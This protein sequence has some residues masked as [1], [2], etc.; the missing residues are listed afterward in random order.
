MSR[1]YRIEISDPKSGLIITPPGFD[2]LLG[3]AT[4]TS[5]VN[6]QTLPGAWNIELDVP[7]IGA[8]TPQG[9]A[10][11]RVWGISRQ[12][13]SQANDLRNK[14]IKI[15]GGMQKGLPLADPKQAGLLVQ[16]TIFQPFG[17]W[18]GVDQTLD[19]VIIPG[20]G[21]A[22]QPGGIGTLQKPKNI[23]LNWRA[24]T[25]LSEALGSTL[26]TAFPG[27]KQT[28]QISQSLTRPN[29]EVAFFPTLEQ[30][31][32]FV[33]QTSK[34]IIKTDGYAGVSIVLDGA[35]ISAFDG[36]A[37]GGGAAKAIGYA[38]LIG[39]PTWIESPN[40][41]IKTVMRGDL[42]TGDGI[43]LPKT[44]VTNTQQAASALVNQSVSFQGG[45]TIVSQRHVGNYRQASA[46]S[47]VTVIEAAPKQIAGSA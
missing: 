42:S 33:L 28:I 15:F 36:T 31:S 20:S 35:A 3:G 27:A 44:V 40:I 43:T 1:Y 30:L 5:F 32:Q 46:D 24:G 18:I 2:G 34:S 41:S 16:G 47:W 26:K 6:D 21:T 14:N 10:L 7:V 37:T 8:A 38:D 25:Q 23:V 12:E 22:D 9:S 17:N 39:Q 11:C 13:I 29:D 4:Y 19:L 45:F